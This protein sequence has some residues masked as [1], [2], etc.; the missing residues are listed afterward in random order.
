MIHHPRCPCPAGRPPPAPH[1]HHTCRLPGSTCDPRQAPADPQVRRSERGRPP[2][3]ARRGVPPPRLP[4]PG[5]RRGFFRPPLPQPKVAAAVKTQIGSAGTA[6][7]A[8]TS[9]PCLSAREEAGP[10]LESFT[11]SSFCLSHLSLGSAGSAA[12]ARSL[13]A[14]RLQCGSVPPPP[15]RRPP[16]PP[17][18]R[19]PVGRPAGRQADRPTG[20]QADRKKAGQLTCC[21]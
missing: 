12:R 21:S 3:G 14:L 6:W 10:P 13:Q 15:P 18:P 19:P 9:L 1:P 2:G 7:P 20:T 17:R 16:P 4:D 8:A 5:G 11:R